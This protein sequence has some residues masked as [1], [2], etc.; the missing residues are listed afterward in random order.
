M[1]LTPKLLETQHFPERFRGY[2]PDAVDDFLERVA[3]GLGEMQARLD[4]VADRIIDAETRASSNGE[5]GEVQVHDGRPGPVES[6]K[7]ALETAPRLE[8]GLAS[9]V[10][11]ANNQG[12]V[13]IGATKIEIDRIAQLISLAQQTADDVVEDAIVAAREQIADLL[14]DVLVASSSELAAT[15]AIARKAELE[16]ELLELDA[17][18]SARRNDADQLAELI[19]TRRRALG[20]IARD[21]SGRPDGPPDQHPATSTI[22]GVAVI[23]ESTTA[24]PDQ[25]AT[26][27]PAREIRS[28]DDIEDPFFSALQR[29]EPLEGE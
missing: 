6:I 22:E 9:S 20:E 29:R 4:D 12:A 11:G 21:L 8:S 18:I 25:G 27:R 5:D 14:A 7:E 2:D 16:S 23:D 1:E 15:G 10:A 28:G 13:A 26:Q 19:E 3:V 24:A 17:R